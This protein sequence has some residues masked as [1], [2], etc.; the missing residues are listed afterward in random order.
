MCLKILI[1]QKASRGRFKECKNMA[2]QKGLEDILDGEDTTTTRGDTI[3]S[4]K[5][6]RKVLKKTEIL[7]CV[8]KMEN[9]FQVRQRNNYFI[10][11]FENG[12]R[13]RR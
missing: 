3:E 9:V 11:S 7:L 5:R 4:I 10:I 13:Q 1:V 2:E 12:Q 6:R 8:P